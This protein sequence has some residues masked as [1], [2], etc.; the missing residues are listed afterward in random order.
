MRNPVLVCPLVEFR[1]RKKS[2]DGGGAEGHTVGGCD[3]DRPWKN[4]ADSAL[5]K[6]PQWHGGGVAYLPGMILDQGCDAGYLGIHVPV[7]SIAFSARG[8]FAAWHTE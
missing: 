1:T 7:E 3:D 5:E 2:V 4:T 8:G 6:W